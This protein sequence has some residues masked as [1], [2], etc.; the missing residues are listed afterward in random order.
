MKSISKEELR[1]FYL[2]IINKLLYKGNLGFQLA[3]I[4][5]R[6]KNIYSNR[7]LLS[8]QQA[9]KVRFKNVHGYEL[10]LNAPI[11]FNEKLQWLKLNDRTELHTKLADK[12]LVREFISKKY[13]DDLLTKIVYQTNDWRNIIKENTP[14]YPFII[15]PNHGS[16][17]FHIIHD[18]S[19]ADWEK[20]KIDC[21]FWLTQNY[22][23]YD[24][25]WQYKFI[26]PCII[27]EKLL[28]SKLDKL[29][30]IYRLHCCSGEVEVI[31]VNILSEDPKKFISIKY[32]KKWEFLNFKFGTENKE[33]DRK[34]KIKKPKHLNKII[35]I[36]EDIAKRFAYVR[37][38]FY[39]LDGRF[40]FNEITFHD[41]GGNDRIFPFEWDIKLGRMINLS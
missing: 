25:E 36:T 38:D 22:Y 18:K 7:L 39:E 20:I 15:K 21:R 1:I 16:G 33:T 34:V 4:L 3:C 28:L 8:D 40:Y 41:S 13:G 2:L 35:E 24:R 26:P 6:L 14:D 27:V 32:N 37:V 10:N 9:I 12:W 5:Y 23:Y 11:S 31:S 29:A 17:W 19:K 30:N